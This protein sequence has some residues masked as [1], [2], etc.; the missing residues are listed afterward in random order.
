MLLYVCVFC[1]Q[2]TPAQSRRHN[3]ECSVLQFYDS[4]DVWHI[5]SAIGMYLYF[6]ML[7]TIDDGLQDKPWQEL[8]VF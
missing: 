1:N 4:H 5:T 8:P 2:E 3:Q 7:L 6:N